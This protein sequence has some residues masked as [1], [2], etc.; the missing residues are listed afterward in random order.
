[1]HN[2]ESVLENETHKL[3]WDFEIWTDHLILD[4]PSE[5]H[6][7]SENLPNCELGCSDRPQSKIE[8]KGKR[9]ISTLTLLGDWKKNKQTMEHETN[10]DTNCNQCAW[11]RHQRIGKGTGRIGNKNT[12][13]DHLNNSTIKVGQNTVKSLGDLRWLG[14]TQTPVKDY[15][16]ILMWKTLKGVK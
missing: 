5:R 16:L 1:M 14:V 6:K 11:Y 9:E 15:Q 8:G 7:E 10:G 2:P 3:F 4:R 12:S 13:G